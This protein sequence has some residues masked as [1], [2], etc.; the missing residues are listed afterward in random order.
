MHI[1][2]HSDPYEVCAIDAFASIYDEAYP[3]PLDL[4]ISS[5]S[6]SFI[7][8]SLAPNAGSQYAWLPVDRIG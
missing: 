4:A 7:L 1:A 3:L 2:S 8:Y 5:L 6:Q